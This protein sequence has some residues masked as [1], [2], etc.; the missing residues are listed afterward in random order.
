MTRTSSY[1]PPYADQG[2]AFDRPEYPESV[3]Y[4]L[5]KYY[6]AYEVFIDACKDASR[7]DQNQLFDSMVGRADIFK[8]RATAELASEGAH[9]I[10]QV[11]KDLLSYHVNMGTMQE[12]EMKV[13]NLVAYLERRLIEAGFLIAKRKEVLVPSNI[14][15]D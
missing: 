4:S 10:R 7:H 15:V 2:S 12:R 5:D 9:T 11:A 14:P 1:R 8:R 3:Q 6:A 13:A